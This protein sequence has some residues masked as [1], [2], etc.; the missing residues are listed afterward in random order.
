MRNSRSSTKSPNRRD[1]F[2]AGALAPAAIAG[3]AAAAPL[4]AAA[5]NPAVYTDL[6][7]KPFIN[8]T[9]TLTINGGSRQLDE[10]IAAIEAAG[11]FHVNLDELMEKAGER[12]AQLL[13]C[14]WAMVTSGAAAA[15]THATSACVA[16]A[17]PEAMQ[18]LPN[19]AGLKNE[20]IMPKW[21]RNQYDHAI[22]AVGVTIVEVETPEQLRN[23][24]T[25]RTA[26][27]A[28]LGEKWGKES[29][30][31]DDFAAAAGGRNI[32]ILIDAAADPLVTPDPYLTRGASLVAYSGG[33]IIRGPQTAG[34]LIGRKDLVKAAF[35]NSAPHHA[36][37]RA[38][39]V[40]K[41]EIVGMVKAVEVWVT[42]RDLEAEYKEWQS[43][44]AHITSEITKVPGVTTKVNPP[45]R[46]GPFPTLTVEWDPTKVA[47]TA[48][49]VGK[50][51]LD[52][53]PRIQTHAAGE[54]TSF[55]IRPVA[56]KPGEHKIVAERLRGILDSHKGSLNR[57]AKQPP[58][59]NVSGNWDVDVE[60]IAGKGKHR[61]FLESSGNSIRG[62]HYGRFRN[63]DLKGSIS[64]AEVKFTSTLPFEGARLEYAFEGKV[65]GDTMTGTLDCGEHGIARWTAVRHLAG[66]VARDPSKSGD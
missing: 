46:G 38:L 60:F 59:S 49:Q 1:L 25:S 6:G 52:G 5:E 34:L 44:Y 45:R 11:R 47:L 8:T 41:E 20:V 14:E 63:G 50:L 58:A 2:R 30:T 31:L 18:Q 40:S 43:W 65:A 19:L 32:P 15:L 62:V 17:D 28:M 3:L 16:G 12:L 57:P 66:S 26:M 9:A 64:A 27:M 33:K 55:L 53:E 22:R 48:G 37:G 10:V 35:L 39:K 4:Q 7:V 21:S 36:V 13:K 51:M 23:A 61:L 29:V 54:G 24:V 56:M 42:R